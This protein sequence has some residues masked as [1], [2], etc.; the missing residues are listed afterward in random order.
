MEKTRF[1][2]EQISIFCLSLAHLLRAGLGAGDALALL[3]RDDQ[4]SRSLLDGLAARLDAG[5]T[6][7]KSLADAGFPA[8]VCGMTAAGEQSGRTEEALFALAEDYQARARLED[9]LRTALLQPLLLLAL[10]A[11][12]LVVLLGWVLPVFDDVYRQLGASLTGVAGALLQIGRILRAGMPIWLPLL[13][14]VGA[15]TFWLFGTEG[16]K[17]RLM[18]CLGRWDLF[19]QANAARLTQVLSMALNSG[20]DS[21]QAMALAWGLGAP[22]SA[23]YQKCHACVTALSGQATLPQALEKSGL[24]P[25]ADCR[26]LEAGFRGGCI[27]TV[28]AQLARQVQ[29][30]SEAAIRRRLERIEPTLVLLAAVL[31]GLV[32]LSVL[33]PLTGIM[34]AIG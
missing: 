31:I 20:L 14:V 4:A 22:G 27:D 2:K 21:E 18:A 23:F 10:L 8:D 1:T 9:Q 13:A 33:L 11:V 19:P 25:A 32:L 16:G 7:S 12:V 30:R 34:A 24:L 5:Q 28:M 17:T 6:L 3:A 26:L 15:G 29:E